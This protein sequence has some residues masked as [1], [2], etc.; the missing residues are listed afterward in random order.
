MFITSIGFA[1]IP[2]LGFI[3][4]GLITIF[5]Y[6]DGIRLY[7]NGIEVPSI[8]VNAAEKKSNI[9]IS[10]KKMKNYY[11]MYTQHPLK[12]KKEYWIFGIVFILKTGE[13]VRLYFH[14]AF[15]S[16]KKKN[17]RLIG[18]TS[19]NLDSKFGR[20]LLDTPPIKPGDWDE[21]N[22]YF[23]SKL[24]KFNNGPFEFFYVYK[25]LIYLFI[26]FFISFIIFNAVP[27]I[28]TFLTLVFI[29]Y[30]FLIY[31]YIRDVPETIK[32]VTEGEGKFIIM[33]SYK[34][35]Y[36]DELLKEVPEIQLDETP[37][38]YFGIKY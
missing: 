27:F 11:Y 32:K 9:F 5:K 33:T 19:K 10:F 36:E 2:A 35:K 1:L 8:Y 16:F 7:E 34:K 12:D 26:I 37:M 25:G 28:Q 18:R 20:K 21:I 22:K 14:S 24:F 15:N 23:N 6:N 29:I 4:S 30:I 17:L 3:I 31:F 38:K 13:E